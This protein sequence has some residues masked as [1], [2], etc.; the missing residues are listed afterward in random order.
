MLLLLHGS[1]L[2]ELL[3]VFIVGYLVFL[4]ISG[5]RRTQRE[6]QAKLGKLAEKQLQQNSPTSAEVAQEQQENNSQQTIAD[7]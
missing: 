1:N 2:D 3:I 4:L 7:K 6:K 5:Y